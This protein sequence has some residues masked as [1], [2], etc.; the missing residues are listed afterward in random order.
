MIHLFDTN[1]KDNQHH[2]SKGNQLKWQKDQMWYKADYTGY[3]GL[4]E[5]VVSALLTYSDL[6]ESLFIRYETEQM[7]YKNRIYLGCKSKNFLHNQWQLITLEQLYYL[8]YGQ[9]LYEAVFHIHGI[10]NRADFLVST[11]ISMTG[12]K[13]FGRYLCQLLT[14]DA[15]FLNED[16]HMH[17]IAVLLDPEGEFH[18]CPVFDNGCSLLADITFDYPMEQDIIDLIP[19]VQSKT[20]SLDFMEQLEAV[21]QL[22]GMPVHFSFCSNDVSNIL[23]NEP[24]YSQEVKNR[25]R[26]ILLQQMRT[27]QY[28]FKK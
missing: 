21:E 18:Y 3:E 8:L 1:M 20:L 6:P 12:L 5:Y 17:N 26:D 16:R 24:F 25:V 14:I 15:L 22:F 4:A 11:V 13:D 10:Q 19:T 27:Y 9:S 7:Q 23:D 2:S 28:L